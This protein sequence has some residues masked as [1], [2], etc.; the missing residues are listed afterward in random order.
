VSL[1]LAVSGVTAASADANA[2]GTPKAAAACIASG[3]VAGITAAL[4]GQNAEA[5]L[6]PSAT[7]NL[8][9]P[10]GFT[11]PNQKCY[12]Q[13]L[14]T[15]ST[16]ATLVVT[17][18]GQSTAIQGNGQSGVILENLQINGNRVARG[19]IAGGAG[20]IEMGGA[21]SNETVQHGNAYQTRGWST[22]HMTEG[23]VTNSTPACQNAKILNNRNTAEAL[24][25][26]DG[27]FVLYPGAGVWSSGTANNAG[28]W[29]SVQNDGNVVLYASGG[30]P[31]W[32]TGTAGH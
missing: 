18:A 2:T 21:G 1:A 14:P 19:R 8:T 9:A 32:S 26:G 24:L 12:T 22:L 28:A 20:L 30:A 16:R 25:Q 11:A 4:Q 10:I 13:G 15:G 5:V 23:M 6:C 7:F 31:L 29:L 17:G 27:N 3:D